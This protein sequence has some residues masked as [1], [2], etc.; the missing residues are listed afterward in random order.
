MNGSIPQPNAC[1]VNIYIA[2]S[3]FILSTH[4]GFGSKATENT[5]AN[6]CPL[7]HQQ[8]TLTL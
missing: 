2:M 6:F 1:P 5:M 7:H 4:V 8:Q 3:I